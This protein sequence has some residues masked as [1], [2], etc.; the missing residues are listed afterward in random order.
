[1]DMTK[2]IKYNTI[3]CGMKRS[4]VPIE[5]LEIRKFDK[6]FTDYEGKSNLSVAKKTQEI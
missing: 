6:D 3:V 2:S 1:M 5:K 4:I